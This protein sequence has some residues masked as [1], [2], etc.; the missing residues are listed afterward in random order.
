MTVSAAV[1]P[2]S[3][4]GAS[5]SWW[6][7]STSRTF[8]EQCCGDGG[9]H[10]RP[11]QAAT[12]TDAPSRAGRPASRTAALVVEQRVPVPLAVALR[13]TK[14]LA[15]T[16]TRLHMGSCGFIL[17]GTWCGCAT[18]QGRTATARRAADMRT[19]LLHARCRGATTPTAVGT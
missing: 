4:D 7:A 17:A 19:V 18:H 5:A 1:A 16:H 6:S 9:G 8:Q 11:L 13:D 12:D 3:G 15:R 10:D 14:R 2:G